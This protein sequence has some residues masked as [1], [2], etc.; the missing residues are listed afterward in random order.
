[1]GFNFQAVAESSSLVNVRQVHG[2]RHLPSSRQL[3]FHT[4]GVVT[5]SEISA[6]Q[7]A[8]ETQGVDTAFNVGGS[9][10]LENSKIDIKHALKKRDKKYNMDALQI[11]QAL[12]R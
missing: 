3:E 12:S 1:L 7:F 10:G 11:N 2:H 4:N 6:S 5:V 9:P 8:V